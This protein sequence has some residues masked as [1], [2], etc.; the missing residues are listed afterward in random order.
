MATKMTVLKDGP[1][2]V[3]GDI[4]VTDAQGKTLAVSGDTAYIC[5]CGASAKK[6][7]CDGGHKKT[8]FQ[9]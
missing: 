6:P 5:R 2:M 8:G 9:G 1:L 3:K 4:D 7:F